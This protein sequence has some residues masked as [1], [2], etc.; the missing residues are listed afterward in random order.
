MRRLLV[1]DDEPDITSG[2]EGCLENYPELKVETVNDPLQALS[3]FLP[4]K[5]DIVLLDIRM[6][7]MSG[8]ELCRRMRE[9]DPE[10]AVYLISAFE[11]RQEE[12]Q[13]VFPRTAISG[14][15]RKPFLARQLVELIDTHSRSRTC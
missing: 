5:Y 6:P 10:I 7:K 9:I 15:L 12:F 4:R 1:V 8:F 13:I 14:F 3:R 11:I 2:I